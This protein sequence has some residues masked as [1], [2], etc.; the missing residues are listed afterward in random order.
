MYTLAEDD[1][2]PAKATYASAGG[3]DVSRPVMVEWGYGAAS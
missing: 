1:D 2:V 3:R